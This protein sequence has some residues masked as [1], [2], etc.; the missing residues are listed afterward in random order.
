MPK[1]EFQILLCYKG[2]FQFD[3]YCIYL[4]LYNPEN[5]YLS[6]HGGGAGNNWGSGYS[7]GER[8]FDEIFDIIDREAEGSENL[9]VIK[10][11]HQ[12]FGSSLSSFDLVNDFFRSTGFH[13]LSFHCWR[14]RFWIGFLHA[15]KNIGTL[16]QKISTNV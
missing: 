15:R 16:P 1:Y 4:K 7:H 5:I 14:N 2:V 8:L 11:K 3:E 13:T 6:K 10:I 12:I 9:E